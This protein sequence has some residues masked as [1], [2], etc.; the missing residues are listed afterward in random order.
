MRSV[1]PCVIPAVSPVLIDRALTVRAGN[2]PD[3]DAGPSRVMRR[4]RSSIGM[5]ARMISA[6][7]MMIA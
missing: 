6:E 3:R 7:M 5:A 4:A 1:A 2:V